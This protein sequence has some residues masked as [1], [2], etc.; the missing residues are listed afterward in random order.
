MCACFKYEFMHLV[1]IVKSFFIKKFCLLIKW[2]D[3]GWIC[4][5]PV[6]R[7]FNQIFRLNFTMTGY[8][9][10]VISGPYSPSFKTIFLPTLNK[11]WDKLFHCP[12]FSHTYL[13]T[14]SNSCPCRHKSEQHRVNIWIS[15]KE[16]WQF[17]NCLS[18]NFKH[19][20]AENIYARLQSFLGLD[21]SRT[22]ALLTRV[23]REALA[24]CISEHITN[25]PASEYFGGAILLWYI[26]NEPVRRVFGLHAWQN[27]CD[28][29]FYCN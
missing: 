13:V 20:N 4:F 8:V 17:V 27:H 3:S 18:C 29:Y 19:F 5:S 25:F 15:G 9:R 7:L 10:N 11:L 12:P 2:R 24:K 28:S 26:I 16:I 23:R 6:L 21:H 1:I 22:R 14:L